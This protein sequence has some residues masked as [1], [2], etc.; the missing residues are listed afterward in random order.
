MH[1]FRGRCVNTFLRLATQPAYTQQAAR[2]HYTPII[3]SNSSR[4]ICQAAYQFQMRLL[5][6]LRH[7]GSED[8]WGSLVS[9]LPQ[10]FCCWLPSM[11]RI[12]TGKMGLHAKHW[13]FDWSAGSFPKFAPYARGYQLNCKAWLWIASTHFS[14]EFKVV[15]KRRINIRFR[16]PEKQMQAELVDYRLSTQTRVPYLSPRFL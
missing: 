3:I 1:A 8:K 14:H 7:V 2:F 5:N 6:P 15:W 13:N 9:L 10:S 4:N 16:H 12:M 11:T